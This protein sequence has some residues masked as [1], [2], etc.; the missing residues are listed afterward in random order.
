MKILVKVVD[1][2]CKIWGIELKDINK[3]LSLL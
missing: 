2:L 1:I 3:I